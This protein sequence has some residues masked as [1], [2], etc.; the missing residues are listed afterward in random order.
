[1][2]ENKNLSEKE[3][4][5]ADLEAAIQKFSEKLESMPE[6]SKPKEDVVSASV[7]KKMTVMLAVIMVI[8][9]T[10]VYSSYAY[11]T[12]T[13]D[14]ASN[15]IKAGGVFFDIADVSGGGTPDTPGT[16]G[17]SFGE[18]GVDNIQIFPGSEVTGDISARNNGALSLY[19]RATIYSS[20]TLD[21]R[22]KDRYNEVDPN[23]VQFEIDSANW[24]KQG[25]YWYYVRAI[26][27]NEKTS[28]FITGINFDDD[29]GNIYKDS[30]V[31]VKVR[32]EVV[33]ANGNGSTPFEA[34]GWPTPT[35]T[36]TEGGAASR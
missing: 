4:Q 1:M 15:V 35:S 32:F 17:G 6:V 28:K 10:F 2:D 5:L 20:I 19:V 27:R 16:P 30:V 3:K 9:V 14:S 7:K 36:P 25:D 31:K 18:A 23:H 12:A 34:T 11:F 29:M 33:Q 21:E 8:T 13:V 22:Y 24:I 26:E